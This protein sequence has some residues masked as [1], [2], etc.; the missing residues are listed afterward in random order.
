MMI[1]NSL[2]GEL[3]ERSRSSRF[4]ADCRCE[5]T[6]A[7]LSVFSAAFISRNLKVFFSKLVNMAQNEAS[8]IILNKED[9]VRITLYYQGKFKN[10][11]DDLKKDI[12]DL[13]SNLY[14]LSQTFLNSRLIYKSLET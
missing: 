3:K 1:S 4:S 6:Y 7:V 14:G 8:L 11:L 10:I 12:S 13:K 9:L 2:M 5:R